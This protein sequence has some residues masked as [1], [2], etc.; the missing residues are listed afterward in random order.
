MPTRVAHPIFNEK[1]T[2]TVHRRRGGATVLKVGGQI[3]L[4]SLA[5]NFLT[6]TFWPVGGKI[7][8]SQPNSHVCVVD[9]SVKA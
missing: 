7:L 1:S 5:E 3:L 4:A 8:L 2:G 9:I 6:P